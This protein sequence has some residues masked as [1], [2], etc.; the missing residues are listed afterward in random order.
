MNGI[1][2]PDQKSKIFGHPRS[3]QLYYVSMIYDTW[4]KKKMKKPINRNA[5]LVSFSFSFVPCANLCHRDGFTKVDKTHV[6]SFEH[7]DLFS[8]AISSGL[9][10]D[11]DGGGDGDWTKSKH[12]TL[13]FTFS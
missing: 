13:W 1:K 4:M 9:F 3:P 12:I 7:R 5:E 8:I 2:P 11:N 6:E 10:Y